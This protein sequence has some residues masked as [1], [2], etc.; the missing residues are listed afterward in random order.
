[1]TINFVCCTHCTLSLLEK[2]GRTCNA[3]TFKLGLQSVGLIR[4]SKDA[5]YEKVAGK[6]Q[7]FE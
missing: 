5:E 1:M 7:E 6:I 2:P 4:E 3:H